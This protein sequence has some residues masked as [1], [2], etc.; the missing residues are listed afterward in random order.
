M[1][2]AAVFSRKYN[3][4]KVLEAALKD[5]KLRPYVE[6]YYNELMSVLGRLYGGGDRLPR[7]A[8]PAWQIG[9]GRSLHPD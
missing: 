5:E 1:R 8:L 9:F 2:N 6:P 7:M 3:E 4:L